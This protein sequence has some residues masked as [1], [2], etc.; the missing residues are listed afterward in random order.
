MVGPALDH[1]LA[2]RRRR[3]PD[4]RPPAARSPG[5]PAGAT[6]VVGDDVF[7]VLEPS[8]H[9]AGATSGSA[10]SATPAAPTSP[11]PPTRPSPTPCGCGRARCGCSSTR[12]VRRP[13][14]PG[15]PGIAELV[16]PCTGRQR[17]GRRRQP[18]TPTPSRASR[19][20]CTPATP[21]RSTSPTASTR[22]PTSTRSRRTS[23]CASSTR[24]RTAASSSTT[25]TA[26][27]PGCSLELAGA[28]RPR[29]RRPAPGDQADQGHHP[30]RR[31]RRG[32]RGAA[33]SGSRATRSSARENLMI[34]DLLRNDL[35]MVCE[36]GSVEVPVADGGRV[37]RVGPPARV[38]GP[39]AAA[40]RR[41]RRSARCARSSR[42][43]R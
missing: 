29:H 34:V 43:A 24:R 28:V 23:G 8:S 35:S 19:S 7:A 38:D 14:I 13:A 21:T 27:A 37:L 15:R 5:T 10:T 41:H 16:R 36:V 12:S 11:P 40:R 9:A 17:P 33:A 25:S 42:P 1:R 22:G 18:P 32:G 6:E 30:A 20:T 31:D 39:R 4:L 3:V 26:R 2:G